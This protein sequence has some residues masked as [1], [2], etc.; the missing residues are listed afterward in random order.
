M[1][2]IP[3]FQCGA[4]LVQLLLEDVDQRAAKELPPPPGS[5]ISRI[6]TEH[7][8]NKVAAMLP[9]K[10]TNVRAVGAGVLP[11]KVRSLI[12]NLPRKMLHAEEATAISAAGTAES[13]MAC[14]GDTKCFGQH[15]CVIRTSLSLLKVALG[16]IVDHVKDTRAIATP[17]Q[18]SQGW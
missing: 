10:S 8:P 2:T 7:L 11:N 17:L 12:E 9:Q 14:A 1:S 16:P 4:Q 3:G 6:V 18:K 13:Y 15:P 5:R